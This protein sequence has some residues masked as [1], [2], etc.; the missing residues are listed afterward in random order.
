MD[1][2][3]DQ[4]QAVDDAKHHAAQLV[5]ALQ[6]ADASSDVIAEAEA[7]QTSVANL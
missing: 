2:M 6:D 7:L 3:R 5:D 1:E 4:T